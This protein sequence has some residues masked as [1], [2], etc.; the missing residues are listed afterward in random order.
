MIEAP[1]SR[2]CMYCF[3]EAIR[4]AGSSPPPQPQIDAASARARTVREAFIGWLAFID[5]L[6]LDQI[7]SSRS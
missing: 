2:R 1:K 6:P 5:L 4:A 3:A 7:G